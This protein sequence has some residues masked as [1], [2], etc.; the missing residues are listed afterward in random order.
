M[1]A[2]DRP[3]IAKHWLRIPRH[4]PTC[5]TPTYFQ[6]PR[7]HGTYRDQ[8]QYRDRQQYNYSTRQK[9]YYA[10]EWTLPTPFGVL[11]G[12]DRDRIFRFRTPSARSLWVASGNADPTKPHQREALRASDEKVEYAKVLAARGEYQ[13]PAI[14]ED[15]L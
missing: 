15:E 1:A 12:P 7:T 13:W 2:N 14:D 5:P 6:R 10:V 4:L 8:Q 9:Y 11:A 3:Q